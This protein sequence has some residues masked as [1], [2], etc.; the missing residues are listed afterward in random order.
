M[1]IAFRWGHLSARTEETGTLCAQAISSDPL[2]CDKHW[3]YSFFYSLLAVCLQR[4]YQKI[5]KGSAIENIYKENIVYRVGFS[6]CICCYFHAQNLYNWDSLIIV[7]HSFVLGHPSTLTNPSNSDVI[8]YFIWPLLVTH[9]FRAKVYHVAQVYRIGWAS[10]WNWPASIS[11]GLGMQA[12]NSLPR[13]L[14]VV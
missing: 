1:I 11:W 6:R 4:Q 3:S 14:F 13:F 8:I 12:S 2:E 7:I 9:I 5:H 10:S